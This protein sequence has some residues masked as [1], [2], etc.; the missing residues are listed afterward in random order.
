MPVIN[1]K[2]KEEKGLEKRISRIDSDVNLVK[3][4]DPLDKRIESLI[5][6]GDQEHAGISLSQ[7]FAILRKA[8][9]GELSE[10]EL[11]DYNTFVKR[12]I[13]KAKEDNN[14]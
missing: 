3:D 2:T 5:R 11:Q 4:V 1:K 14:D 12:C 7:E 10:A 9:V 6:S 13:A 8:I